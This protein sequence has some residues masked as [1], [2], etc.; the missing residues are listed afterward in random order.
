MSF[1][2]RQACKE[3]M[4]LLIEKTGSD[5]RFTD[6]QRR[7]CPAL[8]TGDNTAEVSQ[9]SVEGSLWIFNADQ[10]QRPPHCSTPSAVANNKEGFASRY[11]SN[12]MAISLSDKFAK[13]YI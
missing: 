1:F 11:V 8:E 2:L 9:L 6:A 10:P 7:S 13:T 3:L 12:S 4:R 5:D